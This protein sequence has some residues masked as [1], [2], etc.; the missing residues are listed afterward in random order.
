MSQSLPSSD[1]KWL[2]QEEIE[3]L[4]IQNISSDSETGY[5]LEVD[6]GKHVYIV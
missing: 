2:L 6:L 1:F 5:I 3:A 4:D